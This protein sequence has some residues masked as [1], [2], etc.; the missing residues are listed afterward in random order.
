MMSR[1][2]FRTAEPS[3]WPLLTTASP[4]MRSSPALYDR[5]EMPEGGSDTRE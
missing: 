4:A 3:S 1:A 2:I 5:N